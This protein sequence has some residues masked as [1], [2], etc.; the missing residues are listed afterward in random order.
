MRYLMSIS[1]DGSKYSGMQKL[2]DAKTI[3]GELEEVL[4]KMN[5]KEVFVKAAGRTDKGVHALDQKCHFDIDKDTNPYKLSYYINNATSKYLHVNNLEIVDDNFHARF[6]VK[7]K[8]YVY[9]IN[10]GKYNPIMADYIY[11]YNKDIDIDLLRE[12]ARLFEGMHSY[13]AFVSGTRESYNSIIDEIKIM[14]YNNTV[15]ITFIGKAFYTYMVRNI[16]SALLLAIE[17]KISIKD[18]KNMLDTGE[19]T[20]DFGPAPACGLYLTKVEY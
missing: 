19:K 6:M 8:E 2:K 12:I 18:I 1:Y 17:K 20:Y 10:I 7:R 16:V 3:Q 9:K 15:E 5:E 11:N 13:K 4:T 14:R